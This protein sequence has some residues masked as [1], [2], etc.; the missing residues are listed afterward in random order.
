MHGGA[1]GSQGPAPWPWKNTQVVLSSTQRSC[2][3]EREHKNKFTFERKWA[4][5]PIRQQLI[6]NFSIGP[7]F[8]LKKMLLQAQLE[9]S[10]AG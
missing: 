10:S 6:L 1:S 3:C 4:S 8:G 5:G 2:R 9:A 7:H